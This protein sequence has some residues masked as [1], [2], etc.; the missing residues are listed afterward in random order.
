MA[1]GKVDL[2]KG[3][4]EFPFILKIHS[5]GPAPFKCALKTYK[6]AKEW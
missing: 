1:L 4:E 3:N 6:E 2:E 5:G